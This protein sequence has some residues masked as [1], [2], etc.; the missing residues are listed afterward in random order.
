MPAS[1]QQL[2]ITLVFAVLMVVGIA[3]TRL[4]AARDAVW[5]AALPW[6]LLALFW[7]SIFVVS[8]RDRRGRT[9]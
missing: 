4:F 6:V 3:V 7:L 8:R 2:R 5:A 1:N 9:E